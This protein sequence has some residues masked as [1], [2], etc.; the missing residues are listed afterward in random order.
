VVVSNYPAIAL[1]LKLG[2]RVVGTV[3][4]GFCLKDGGYRD[5]LIFLLT[6]LQ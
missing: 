2:F 4:N 3:R 6:W 5:T 1:Y